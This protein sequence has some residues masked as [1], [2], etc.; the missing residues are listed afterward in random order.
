MKNKHFSHILFV[1]ILAMAVPAEAGVTCANE[2][3]LVSETTPTSDFLD[4]L[5]GTVTHYKTELT[6]M[7]CSLGQLWVNG[8]CTGAPSLYNWQQAF[9]AASG[10]DNGTSDIDGD[11]RAGFAGKTDW[12]LPNK[13]E[14]ASI[15][16]ERCWNP[17]INETLFPMT[18][19]YWYWSSTP[20]IDSDKVRSINF[21]FVLIGEIL[22]NDSGHVRLVRGGQ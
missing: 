2:N 7:R 12:R 3:T 13:N 22:K 15:T 4:N 1:L 17:A 6:W 20:E 14:L 18:P 10:L 11:E 8:S 19:A 21:Y 5:D 9:Q 16:E